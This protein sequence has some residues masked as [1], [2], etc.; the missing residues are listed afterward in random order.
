M[1]FMNSDA[2]KD[3][4]KFQP[5]NIPDTPSSEIE[6]YNISFLKIPNRYPSYDEV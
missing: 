5:K 4:E 2:S 6:E 3:I 1:T